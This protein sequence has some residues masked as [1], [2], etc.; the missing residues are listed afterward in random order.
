MLISR[1]IHVNKGVPVDNVILTGILLSHIETAYSFANCKR[2]LQ[3]IIGLCIGVFDILITL[4]RVLLRLFVNLVVIIAMSKIV[5][6][7]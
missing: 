4:D 1:L 3:N 5:K 2:G 6:L 7:S